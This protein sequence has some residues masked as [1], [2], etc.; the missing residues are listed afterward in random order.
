[1]LFDLP[2]TTSKKASRTTAA[3]NGNLAP[4]ILPLLQQKE[5]VVYK[6]KS[7]RFFLVLLLVWLGTQI[8]IWG[9]SEFILKGS[10][11]ERVLELEYVEPYLKI[12]FYLLFPV[13]YA[14]TVT[15]RIVKKDNT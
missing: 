4:V 3:T 2:S 6:M 13:P 8:V 5:I 11:L 7:L 9:W 10:Q 15:R 12:P 1:M 14:V